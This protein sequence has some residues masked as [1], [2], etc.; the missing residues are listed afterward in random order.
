[1]CI[2]DRDIATPLVESVALVM[3]AKQIGGNLTKALEAT[4]AQADI[5]NTPSES[6]QMLSRLIAANTRSPARILSLIHI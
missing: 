1:M 6:A 2:R 4:I 5:F 3:N